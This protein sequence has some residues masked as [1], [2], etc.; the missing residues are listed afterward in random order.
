MPIWLSVVLWKLVLPVVISWLQKEGYVNAAEA[1]AAK[2]TV[3]LVN[4]VKSLKTYDQYPGDA[5]APPVT[6]NL[7]SGDGNP[8]T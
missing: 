7:T 3:A 1:L 4:E 5:P 2:G 6:T 8:V